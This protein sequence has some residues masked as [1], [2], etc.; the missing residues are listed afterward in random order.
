VAVALSVDGLNT[1]DARETTAA[2]A[3][4]W[5]LDPYQIV[6]ISGW[7]TSQ[8]EAR[9][10]EDLPMNAQSYVRRMQQLIGKPIEIVSVGPEREQVILIDKPLA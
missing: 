9:R 6:T 7:Q 1:I 2:G 8:T 10:F 4:K 3:R 5:V